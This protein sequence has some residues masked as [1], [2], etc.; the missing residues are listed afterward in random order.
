MSAVKKSPKPAKSKPRHSLR[1]APGSVREIA[2]MLG[3]LLAKHGVVD[4]PAIY[5][6]EGYDNYETIG[7]VRAVA[8]DLYRW[9]APNDKL[10]RGG[11]ND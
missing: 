2:I 4:S 3:M 8:E 7:R 9:H 1:A 11:D 5:D 10:R 6:P